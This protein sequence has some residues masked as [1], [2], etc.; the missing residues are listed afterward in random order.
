M[1]SSARGAALW[2]GRGIEAESEFG[3]VAA[4]RKSRK[5]KRAAEVMR[6][7]SDAHL[8]TFAPTGTGKTRNCVIP[9]L[10]QWP[11]SA[12]VV[13]IKKGELCRV[14]ARRRRE[15]GQEVVV[16][17]PFGET[18][19]PTGS[20]NPLELFSLPSAQV[21]ADSETLAS[22]LAGS[23][24]LAKDPFWDL[25]GTAVLAGV[26]AHVASA[27][28]DKR[29][30]SEVI[31]HL[32]ADDV[33]YHL[34]TVLDSCGKS[35]PR[36][37]YRDIASLLAM[38]DVTRGGVLATTQSYLKSLH[39]PSVLS[40][41]DSTS[42]SLED[43]ILGRPVTIYLVLPVERLKSHR[44]LLRLWIGT[45]LRAIACRSFQ[46]E[47]P[48]LVLLDECGQLGAFPFLETFITLCRAYSCRVWAFFQDL[49]QLEEA[50]P[51]A[52]RTILNNC[53]LSAFGVLN[54]RHAEQWGDYFE[55]PAGALR[56][57]DPGEQVVLLPGRGE[58]RLRKLD[59]LNDSEFAGLYDPN[60][61][62]RPAPANI[63]AR[64]PAASEPATVEATG[65]LTGRGKRKTA[66][67]GGGGLSP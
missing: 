54:R 16:L 63:L 60:P 17:D 40:S 32:F 46:A 44:A 66:G 14:T 5:A 35:M 11:G 51:T 56:T 27:S 61:L 62:Y 19:E 64:R 25:Q 57:M 4:V 15:L 52:W 65:A 3:F 59:Y 22:L 41:L 29:N 48:T 12:V 55:T 43:F 1:T 13:D 7:A 53:A 28:H 34:A 49:A 38:P 21:E 42:F 67:G 37:A 8:L 47:S 36:C 18:G 33:I 2:L 39:S 24:A 6:D 45:L 20:L 31:G 30:M 26:L 23:G 10:L 50:Y 9:N 58:R